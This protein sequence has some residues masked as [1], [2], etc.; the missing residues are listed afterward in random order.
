MTDRRISMT[1]LSEHSLEDILDK[2]TS[3]FS[4]PESEWTGSCKIEEPNDN[5]YDYEDNASGLLDL[6]KTEDLRPESDQP[7]KLFIT[8]DNNN[9]Y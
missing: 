7:N 8:T 4:D 5:N 3:L 1:E 2:D 6:D 9:C